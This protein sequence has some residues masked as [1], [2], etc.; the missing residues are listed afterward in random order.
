MTTTSPQA[1]AP[2]TAYRAAFL[3]WLACAHAGAGEPAAVAARHIGNGVL[4]PVA[5]AGTAGHVLDFDDTYLPGLAHLT[6][7]T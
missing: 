7:P 6:A 3:D 1:A 4:E 5:T 2:T